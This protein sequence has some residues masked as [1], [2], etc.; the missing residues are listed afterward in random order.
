MVRN[1]VRGVVDFARSAIYRAK[2]AASRTK[3]ALRDAGSGRSAGSPPGR[4][5]G[6]CGAGQQST[7]QT[8]GR[9]L[10]RLRAPLGSVSRLA[11]PRYVHA[12]DRPT[13][14]RRHRRVRFR[15]HGAS[16]RDSCAGSGGCRFCIEVPHHL[17]V[18]ADEPDRHDHDRIDLGAGEPP[19]FVVHV[20]FEPRD[21]GGPDRLCHTR[22]AAGPDQ[23]PD[24]RRGGWLR[25]VAPRSRRSTPSTSGSSGR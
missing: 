24:Q 13:S 1:A 22:C 17:D 2:R 20:R 3:R 12:R 16:E 5:A 10:E 21:L 18:I 19:D 7:R 15:C 23:R 4:P 11:R 9:T 6:R 14:Q 8:S 25:R